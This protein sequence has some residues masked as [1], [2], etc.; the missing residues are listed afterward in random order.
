MT[1][2]IKRP[3]PVLLPANAGAR[4][5]LLAAA[6]WGSAALA[7]TAF[8]DDVP[9]SPIQT[10]EEQP[11]PVYGGPPDDWEA[12]P[13]AEYGIAPIDEPVAPIALYGMA[14]IGPRPPIS[15]VSPALPAADAA[16]GASFQGD[17]VA[18]GVGGSG[19]LLEVEAVYYEWE[20]RD[21]TER[22][23]VRILK[24]NLLG[25][26]ST[27]YQVERYGRYVNNAPA[28]DQQEA[29]VV[30]EDKATMQV[31][32]KKFMRFAEKKPAP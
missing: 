2:P 8:A 17:W 25:D 22:G 18:E 31:G 26:G 7:P 15:P 32:S 24:Q 9:T 23:Q 28:P 21:G 19:I 6:L 13:V 27:L 5:R 11:A 29:W 12:P 10:A 20:A 16:A 14:P 4:G 1:P 3:R 30:S